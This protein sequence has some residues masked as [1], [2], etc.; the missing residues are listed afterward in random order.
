M[1][2]AIGDKVSLIIGRP[3]N[4]G[5]NVYIGDD[6]IDG[7]L[8]HNEIF[9]PLELGQVIDGYIKNIREDGKI[10]VSLQP[11]GFQNV[12]DQNMSIILTQ[13]K[14]RQGYLKL[15]DK[16]EPELIKEKLNMSKK[17][18]KS[19]VGQLYKLK[20]ITIEEDGIYLVK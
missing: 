9:Q 18:F 4:L 3:T 5:V 6:Q 10:D 17:A 13:L 14:A 8:Y 1:E 2:Y 15:T 7:L 12:I 16:S 20:K 19:A 11:Q